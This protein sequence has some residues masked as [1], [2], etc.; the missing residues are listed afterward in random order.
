MEV[1]WDDDD[2]DDDG[3]LLQTSVWELNA[4]TYIERDQRSEV[5]TL[6]RNALRFISVTDRELHVYIRVKDYEQTRMWWFM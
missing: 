3:L 5:K 6:L 2:D 1:N 4:I